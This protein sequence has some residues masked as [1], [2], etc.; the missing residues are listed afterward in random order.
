[1]YFVIAWILS[2]IFGEEA[3]TMIGYIPYTI[4]YIILFAIWPDWNWS[5]F[6]YHA[7]KAWFQW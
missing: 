7:M 5:D 1:M 4:I 2:K 6:D 3:F